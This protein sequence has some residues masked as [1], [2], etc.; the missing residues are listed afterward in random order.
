[1]RSDVGVDLATL[2]RPNDI[3]SALKCGHPVGAL[4]FDD[5]LQGVRGYS[6]MPE[7]MDSVALPSDYVA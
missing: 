7:I 4:A 3:C 6:S 5:V 2:Q 1:M